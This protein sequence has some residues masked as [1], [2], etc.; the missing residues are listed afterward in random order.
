MIFPWFF[1][2]KWFSRPVSMEVQMFPMCW[3]RVVRQVVK[4]LLT[5]KADPALVPMQSPFDEYVT[6]WHWQNGWGQIQKWLRDLRENYGKL[7]QVLADRFWIS[8]AGTRNESAFCQPH[9]LKVA[10]GVGQTCHGSSHR[11]WLGLWNW[12]GP[13]NHGCPMVSFLK[14]LTMLMVFMTI[15]VL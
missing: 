8:H 10:W 9:D 13:V 14:K 7:W 2:L 15:W 1:P 6:P 5:Y 11:R 4:L 3:W 12:G